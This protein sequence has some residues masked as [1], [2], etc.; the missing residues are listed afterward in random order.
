[1]DFSPAADS[2]NTLRLALVSKQQ[3]QEQSPPEDGVSEVPSGQGN[4]SPSSTDS[5]RASLPSMAL[6]DLQHFTPVSNDG[7][8]GAQ[9]N[10]VM[11]AHNPLLKTALSTKKKDG[12]GPQERATT[13]IQLLFAVV[14]EV[15]QLGCFSSKTS[16]DSINQKKGKVFSLAMENAY[17]E[18]RKC[19]DRPTQTY[20]CKNITPFFHCFV[21][22]HCCNLQSFI[23]EKVNDPL[24]D[25][26]A[27]FKFATEKGVGFCRRLCLERKTLRVPKGKA[28]AKEKAAAEKEA[29]AKEQESK[30]GKRKRNQDDDSSSS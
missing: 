16:I 18:G 14:L 13:Q 22:C 25:V 19:F 30:G 17:A 7:E 4:T 5:Q 3:Q 11:Y 27:P 6:G 23:Q 21:K 28:A 9:S 10:R 26:F 24:G 1:M 12:M 15:V 2:Q 8:E 29:A 20:V